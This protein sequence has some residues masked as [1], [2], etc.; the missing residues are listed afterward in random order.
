MP[1]QAPE[2][3]RKPSEYFH[4]RCFV[5]IEPEDRTAP[6]VLASEDNGA[7]CYASDYCHWDCA[8]PDSVRIVA[9]REDL[10]DGMKRAIFA[11]NP[12]RLY[13]L[14]LPAEAR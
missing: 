7:V 8:F 1:E 4:E 5:T 11:G 6:W 3:D 2:I 9:E 12:A 14:A 10:D 13:G